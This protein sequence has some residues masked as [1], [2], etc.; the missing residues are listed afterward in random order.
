MGVGIL[1][2]GLFAMGPKRGPNGRVTGAA[3]PN[4]SPRSA[5]PLIRGDRSNG[6]KAR[7]QKR[8][9]HSAS[10]DARK[11]AYVAGIHVFRA[12]QHQRR[13]WPGQARP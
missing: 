2:I 9:A 12:A 3:A 13:G 10:E 11:R 5:P 6:A 8:A 1:E 4:V 7:A